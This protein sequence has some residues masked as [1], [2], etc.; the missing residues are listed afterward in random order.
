MEI[1]EVLEDCAMWR[2][3]RDSFETVWW[4][5]VGNKCEKQIWQMETNLRGWG[6]DKWNQGKEQVEPYEGGYSKDKPRMKKPSWA[7]VWVMGRLDD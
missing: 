3:Q 5:V 7:V 1:G 6:M 2:N 4:G